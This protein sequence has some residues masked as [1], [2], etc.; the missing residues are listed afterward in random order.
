MKT[1]QELLD[2]YMDDEND[3]YF[4]EV[5]VDIRD[6]LAE[7]VQEMKKWNYSVVTTPADEDSVGTTA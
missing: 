5:F 1:K 3:L 7:I 2:Q 4:I 6:Q